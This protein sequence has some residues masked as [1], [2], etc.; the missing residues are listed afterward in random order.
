MNS[1]AI[2]LHKTKS[3]NDTSGW[4]KIQGVIDDKKCSKEL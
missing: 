4:L 2:S 3:N 1:I